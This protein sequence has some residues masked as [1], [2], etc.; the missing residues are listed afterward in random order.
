MGFGEAVE[1]G[2]Q[3]VNCGFVGADNYSA[4]PNLLQFANGDFGVRGEGQQPGRVLEQEPPGLG[5]GA[6]A[7]RPIEKPVAQLFLEPPNRLA[8]RRLRPV[9]LLRRHR[10]AALRRDGDECAKILQLHKDRIIT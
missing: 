4:A 3:R 7:H 1:V 2:E 6:V 5:Q 10:E 9:Q 8:D